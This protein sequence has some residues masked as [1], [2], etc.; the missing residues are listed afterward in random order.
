MKVSSRSN[1][2]RPG[3]CDHKSPHRQRT[4]RA[5][6]SSKRSP[7]T[8]GAAPIRTWPTARLGRQSSCIRKGACSETGACKR[9]CICCCT[10]TRRKGQPAHS[11][12]STAE[13]SISK[14]PTSQA[15]KRKP[16]RRLRVALVRSRGTSGMGSRTCMH[17]HRAGA[18]LPAISAPHASRRGHRPTAPACDRAPC[19]S[20]T[21]S[22]E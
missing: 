2:G 1:H 19:P 13:N 11:A 4:R 6:A 10:G 8:P 7:P 3:S 9:F 18:S 14:L 5:S 15:T 16:G 12:N 21:V 22:Q 20:L 17:C